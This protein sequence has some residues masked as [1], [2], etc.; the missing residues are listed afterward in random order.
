MAGPPSVRPGAHAKPVSRVQVSENGSYSISKV[1]RNC[2]VS[3]GLGFPIQGE[4]TVE[5][6]E[7]VSMRFKVGSQRLE[8]LTDVG[9]DGCLE[10]VRPRRRRRFLGHRFG[11]GR[12]CH[13]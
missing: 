1:A 2:S 10:R 9:S 8:L 13:F 12:R 11:V 4:V 5:L 6:D 3:I 7:L